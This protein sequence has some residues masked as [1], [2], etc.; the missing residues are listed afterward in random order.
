MKSS[1]SYLNLLEHF[2]VVGNFWC[3]EEYFEKAQLQ[4]YSERNWIYVWDPEN[5]ITV[6]PPMNVNFG[7]GA[8]RNPSDWAGEFW[9]DF[10]GY[11]PGKDYTSRPLDLEY[12]FNPQ[13][14]L[15]M[16]G[17]KWA[18]FRK[19]S[20][21]FPKR[22]SDKLTYLTPGPGWWPAIYE[23]FEC[24]A[25][26]KELHEREV[27]LKYALY[28]KNRRLLVAE[29]GELLGINAWDENWARINYRLCIAKPGEAFLNEY[30]RLCFYTDP[31]I[32]EKNKIVNDGGILDN[33]F[34]KEFKDKL[35]P[36]QVRGVMSWIRKEAL[37]ES[38]KTGIAESTE[39]SNARGS[40]G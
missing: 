22:H 26:G 35:C 21:K 8:I 15:N 32:L 38:K 16:E 36:M 6:L 13:D 24:W 34:L 37:G 1:S 30:L 39:S 14:F 10:P 5:F 29:N 9:S 28:G 20:R 12:L 2:K 33:K 3:S 11:F 18:V 40:K 31:L 7:L 23:L 17:G 25:N 27:L 4:E 19:N